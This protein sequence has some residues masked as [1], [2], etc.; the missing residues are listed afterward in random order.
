MAQ[1]IDA[2]ALLP[3]AS[4]GYRQTSNVCHTLVGN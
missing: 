1:F 2:Y 4:M 3:W